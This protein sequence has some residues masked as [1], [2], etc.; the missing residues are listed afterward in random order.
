MP[1][2]LKRSRPQ[3]WFMPFRSASAALAADE[4]PALIMHMEVLSDK[5]PV[6]SH[7]IFTVVRKG[8]KAIARNIVAHGDGSGT[9]CEGHADD[10][11]EY[12]IENELDLVNEIKTHGLM[13]GSLLVE[14]TVPHLHLNTELPV[15]CM[16]T[17]TNVTNTEILT[18][19]TEDTRPEGTVAKAVIKRV[20]QL[21]QTN[22]TTNHTHSNPSPQNSVTL[23]PK[24]NNDLAAANNLARAAKEMELIKKYG[25]KKIQ[26]LAR[27]MNYE[28]AGHKYTRT[29]KNK[30]TNHVN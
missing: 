11:A 24:Q 17:P 16:Q 20:F 19:F 23:A 2:G 18:K 5:S 4:T 8:N 29:I 15:F 1:D 13:L 10:I 9:C 22:A 21:D 6:V 28:W 30:P 25:K 3:D 26:D 7:T 14:K 27:K 12:P